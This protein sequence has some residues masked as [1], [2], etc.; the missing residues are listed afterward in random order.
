MERVTDMEKIRE[1]VKEFL[2]QDMKLTLQEYP[3]GF[4]V[5][6]DH[7]LFKIFDFRGDHSHNPKDSDLLKVLSDG[8]KRLEIK[9]KKWEYLCKQPLAGIVRSFTEPYVI[10]FLKKIIPVTSADDFA[11]ALRTAWDMGPHGKSLDSW[12]DNGLKKEDVFELLDAC[13]PKKLMT[14]EE[15]KEFSREKYP[16]MVY[17]SDESEAEPGQMFSWALEPRY[18]VDELDAVYGEYKC[19]G[20]YEA[21]INPE[22]VYARI[23]HKGVILNPDR[24]QDIKHFNSIVEVCDEDDLPD[25]DEEEDE[26]ED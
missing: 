8:E 21:T 16:L 7:P 4:S 6:I 5:V 9:E 3:A 11:V 15:Y 13:N 25:R 19:Y 26:D 12:I 22:D 24:L 20:C 23:D 10:P 17:R 2:E 1:T 18:V 14:D